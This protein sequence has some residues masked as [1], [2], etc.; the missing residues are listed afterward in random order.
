MI[1]TIKTNLLQATSENDIKL[2]KNVYISWENDE[3]TGVTCAK[4]ES[5]FEDFSR[6]ICTPG[7]IDTHVHLS[8]YYARGK[9]ASNLLDWLNTYIFVE[10]QKAQNIAYA[11]QTAEMFFKALLKAGT[12]CSLVYTAPF[13]LACNVAFEVAK[14]MQIRTYIGMTMMDCNC[15]DF[16]SQKTSESVNNS[17]DLYNK[18]N[19]VD[20]LGYA[21]TPRFAPV[22]TP[23]L[24][25]QIADFAHKNNAIIQ[26]HLS[27]NLSE[28]EWVKSLYPTA[29]NYT[30][31]YKQN[32]ILGKNTVMAHCIHLNTEELEILAETET[33]ISHCPDSNF[34]LK[35]GM[36][37]WEKVKK[38]NIDF[39]IATDVAAGTSFSL[40][41]S[42]KI[43]N[44]R[45]L[46]YLVN[47]VEAFYKIT[48]GA[49]KII[50]QQHKL[51][52]VKPGF[53]ADFVMFEIENFENYSAEEICSLLCYTGTEL[54]V[55]NIWVA[56]NNLKQFLN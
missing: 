18:W 26:T 15:P 28:L 17:I 7:F 12:T 43:A 11:K 20:N 47:P 40:L 23:K 44:Y 3:I 41:N 36:F 51:G 31:V 56:G 29:K 16:L 39:A 38:A 25:Q 13:K 48:Q 22:C 50:N 2:V 10:E 53:K 1:K 37:N 35:S 32:N 6:Y 4:P 24:M 33:K 46:N 8:Q 9:H 42:C 54:P 45:Q 30:D 49:A 52:L 21:F 14:Q 19:D 34:F 5:D 27:E 55:K